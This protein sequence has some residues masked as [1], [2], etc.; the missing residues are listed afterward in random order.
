MSVLC[1]NLNRDCCQTQML[2]ECIHHREDSDE[3]P[4]QKWMPKER[5]ES[6]TH[7]YSVVF[8]SSILQVEDC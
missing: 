2:T 4:L 7:T 6:D 5:Q 3:L 1:L 8:Y